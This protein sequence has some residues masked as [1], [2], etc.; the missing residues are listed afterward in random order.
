[1]KKK[2]NRFPF[3]RVKSILAFTQVR[4]LLKNLHLNYCKMV[5]NHRKKL[6]VFFYEKGDC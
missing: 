5:F 2:E 4:K 6:I 1:M 3:L